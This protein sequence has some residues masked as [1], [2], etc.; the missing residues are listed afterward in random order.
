[1]TKPQELIENNRRWVASRLG[2]DPLFFQR[3]A[4]SQQ[5]RILWIG[6]V[7]SRVPPEQILDLG[8]GAMLVHRNVANLVSP[9]DASV[10]AVLHLALESLKVEHII[11]C[12]HYLCAGVEAALG[13]AREEGLE[14][15][16]GSIRDLYFRHRRELDSLGD[17]RARWD[18]LSELNVRQQ[19]ATLTGLPV[20][21]SAYLRGQNLTVHGWI[22]HPGDGL[23]RDLGL[24]LRGAPRQALD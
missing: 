12:G 17:H 15:W 13:P 11:V 19:V 6:C 9:T 14:G 1:M 4:A 21:K 7:D 2:E 18:R 20:V 23:V 5:P 10:S 8:P 16:I 3:L 22:Y 24:C